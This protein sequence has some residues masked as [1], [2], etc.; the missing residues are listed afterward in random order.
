MIV[1]ERGI[2]SKNDAQVEDFTKGSVAADGCDRSAVVPVRWY[3]L[4]NMILRHNDRIA[5]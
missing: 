2:Y 1:N 4:D 5:E 3:L